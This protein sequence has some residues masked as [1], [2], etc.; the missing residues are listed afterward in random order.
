MTLMDILF[1]IAVILGVIL[2]LLYFLNQ[3]ATK[4]YGAQQE[5]IESS[6]ITTDIFVLHKKKMRLKDANFPKAVSNQ[7]PK[8]YSFIKMPIIKAKLG[9]QIVSLICD[10]KIFKKITTNKKYKIQLAGIYILDFA[11]KPNKKN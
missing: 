3:W 9:N 11:N 8:F 4:K 7:I 6:K 10:K 1:L 5:L 2:I